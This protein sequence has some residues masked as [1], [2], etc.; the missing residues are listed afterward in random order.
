MSRQRKK[1]GRPISGWIILDKPIGMGSTECVSKLK[2]LYKAAKAGHAGT[3][4][5][6][7]SGMLPIAL[8]EATKTVPYVMDGKKIYRFTVKWGAETNTDDLEGEVVESSAERPSKEAIEAL[9][10]NYVGNISQVPPAYSAIKINGE[11]AYKLARD[12]EDVT[13]EPRQVTIDNLE[14]LEHVQEDGT[15]SAT[16]FEAE[17]GKGTYVRSLAR[18]MGRDLNCF[19]HISSLRRTGVGPFFEED[20]VVL[21]SL[22][23]LEGDLEALDENIMATGTALEYL[24]EV[25][26]DRTQAQRLRSGNPIILRGRD[27]LA[28]ANDACAV[29]GDELI[30]LGDVEQGS[31]HPRRVFTASQY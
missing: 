5:P 14:I 10:D 2:W 29:C 28:F 6:L 4:D 16:V 8:G 1:K 12:G 9:I 24:A 17:C 18:D 27:A 11:R 30:A 15:I 3:L 31:F 23:V 7:A 22:T 13:L 25:P 20:L 19:G 21:E 26:V